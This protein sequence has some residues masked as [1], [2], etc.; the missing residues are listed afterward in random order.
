MAADDLLKKI[1]DHQLLLSKEME[2]R[3]KE[4]L[5]PALKET[6]KENQKHLEFLLQQN[7][8]NPDDLTKMQEIWEKLTAEIDALRKEANGE[9]DVVNARE[10][11]T[12]FYQ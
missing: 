5:T 10:K 7:E 9:I 1:F 2:S 4:H 3:L 6:F 12:D 8:P 11:I